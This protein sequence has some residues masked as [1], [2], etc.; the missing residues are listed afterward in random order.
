MNKDFILSITGAQVL[1]LKLRDSCIFHSP[2]IALLLA[3]VGF[4]APAPPELGVND[5][6]KQCAEFFPGDECM[7]CSLPEGWRGAGFGA[8]PRGYTEGIVKPI[9]QAHRNVFCCTKG[10]SGAPGDC[11]DIVFNA[12]EEACAF[13]S[14]IDT[15]QRL[16]KGWQR[17]SPDD[18]Q[19][20]VCPYEYHWRADIECGE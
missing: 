9:C 11:D 15:C 10:H 16:P 5:T 8:C 14:D 7:A 1:R 3:G 18:F 2:L 4:A 20:Q 13:V 19:E 6:T 17:A 12:Q